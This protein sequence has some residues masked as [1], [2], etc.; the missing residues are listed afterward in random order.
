MH[1]ESEITKSI[2]HNT[3]GRCYDLDFLRF[4]TT[5]GEKIGAFLKKQCYG[6]NFA[7]F[8]FVLIQKRKLFRT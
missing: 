2:S 4:L 6:Q 3:W 8:A 7:L 1:F 5:F